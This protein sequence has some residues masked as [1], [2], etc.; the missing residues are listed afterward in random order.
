MKASEQKEHPRDKEKQLSDHAETQLGS[1]EIKEE[2]PFARLKRRV[3][4]PI[5]EKLYRP[6]NRLL[7]KLGYIPSALLLLGMVGAST[8]GIRIWNN[9]DEGRRALTVVRFYW[10]ARKST[11]PKEPGIADAA[12]DLTNRLKDDI[13][14][15]NRN[16]FGYGDWTEA[17]MVV[18]LQG[19][20]AFEPEEITQWFNQEAKDCH[21]W[22]AG[23]SPTDAPHL[24]ATAYVL[25]A[26][27]RMRIKPREQEID[28]VLE[29]QHRPGWWPIFYSAS[30]DPGNAS[31]YATAMATWALAELLQRDLVPASRRQ[32]VTEAIEKGRKWLLDNTLQGKPGRWKDYPNGIYGQESLAVSGLALHALHRTGPTPSAY[33][34]DWMAS[35]PA[36]LPSLKAGIS[37]G[38]P[39]VLTT[40][41]TGDPTHYFDLPWL[42]IGI[43]DAYSHGSLSQKA[44]AARLIHKIPDERGN[45]GQE[46]KDMPWLAAETLIALRHLQGEDII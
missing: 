45:I 20:D 16:H 17:E 38:Q 8:L 9:P 40:G 46:L 5:E 19:R 33:D 26:F 1:A 18:S 24:G 32:R 44:Q 36:E 13:S 4:K 15:A 37:P 34:E 3:L 10:D 23:P 12:R 27:A 6:L 42:I 39:V 25:L 28:F 30:D 41:T 7:D 11:L 29:N 35:L 14:P 43:T 31:T 22:R 2:L 21:C